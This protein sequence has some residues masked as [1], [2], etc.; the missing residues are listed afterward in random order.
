MNGNAA[1]NTLT[2]FLADCATS[3]WFTDS[4]NYWSNIVVN[5]DPASNCATVAANAEIFRSA[6]RADG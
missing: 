2:G 5:P 1:T 3:F 4:S 6:G